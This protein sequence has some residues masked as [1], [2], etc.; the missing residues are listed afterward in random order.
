MTG[1]TPKQYRKLVICACRLYHK[2]PSAVLDEAV[3]AAA[4]EGV[5]CEIVPDLCLEAVSDRNPCDA[6]LVLACQPRAVRAMF[7]AE[8]DCLDAQKVSPEALR[9]AIRALAVP[10]DW[11]PWFP[12]IDET[13]CVNC[14][15]CADFCMFGV[16]EK[17]NDGHFRV[18][19]P[20]AC[21]TDCPACA[22]ICP[23]NAIIFPK[24]RE[25]RLNGAL[26]EPVKPSLDDQTSFRE[27]LEY[28]KKVRLFRDKMR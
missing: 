9:E 28:R 15:K 3:K 11:V 24:S 27:R 2:I 14:G 10:P 6:A 19:H 12:V 26:D 20:A 4:S 23:A 16:Y 1:E 17:K 5:P 18:V 7:G 13:R 22:R 25:D 21:K 8:T